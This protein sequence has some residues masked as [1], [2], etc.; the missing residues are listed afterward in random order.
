[1]DQ[2]STIPGGPLTRLRSWVLGV[3]G[4]RRLALAC[5]LGALATGALPP[6]HA[7]IVLVPAFSGLVWQI[8]ASPGP[9]SALAVGWWFGVGYFGAGCIG[10]ST[11][12]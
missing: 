12:C 3:R 10:F 9:R 7:V 8:E 6:A 2:V 11:P 1:M 4:W 5:G